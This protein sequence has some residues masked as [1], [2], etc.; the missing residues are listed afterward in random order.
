MRIGHGFDIHRLVE[1]RPLRLGGVV[2][3]FDYGLLGHSDGDVVLHAVA[4][5]LLG[6]LADGDLGTHFP[7]TDPRYKDRDSAEL[8]S[9]VMQR[10]RA[11]RHTVHNLDITIHAERP[12]LAPHVEAMRARLAEL[13]AI[14]VDR[15]SVKAKTMEG[16]DAV[17]RGEA[18]G[19]TAVVL[20]EPV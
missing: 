6:A 3:P 7:D 1:G 17:G 4:D 9:T 20:V 19:A 18:I 14:G 10:V 5:A 15:V 8:L 2:I 13:L 11:R 16:L 12:K